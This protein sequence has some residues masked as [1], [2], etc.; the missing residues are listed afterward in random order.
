MIS[1]I[2]YKIAVNIITYWSW[3]WEA[4]NQQD[5]LARTVL[6]ITVPTLVFVWYKWMLSR[7][8]LPPGPYGLPVIGYLPFLSSNL[9]EKFT[10]MAHKYGPIFSLQLGSKLHVVVNSMDLVKVVARE[11]DHTFANRNPP[12]TGLTITYGGMDLVWSNNNTHWRNMRKLLVSKVLS[13]ENLKACQGLRTQEVRK[14]VNEVYARIGTK[15]DINKISFDTGINVV[16]NM[17]WGCSK[18]NEGG[19][20]GHDI[21]DG[22]REVQYKIIE[23]TGT[24]NISDF[25][26]FLSRFDLQGMNQE[27]QRQLEHV[28]RIFDYVIERTM[29]ANSNKINEE[30][31]R[32]DFV[33]ILLELKDEKNDP[34]SFNIIHIKALLINIVVAATDTTTTMVEWVIAEILNNPGVMK[35]V[36]DELTEVIGTTNIVEESHLPKLTYLDAVIKETFRLHPPLPFLIQRCPDEPCVVGGYTIPKGTVVYINVWAIQRDPENWVNPLQF[37][38]E[39]FLKSKWDY[40]G[41]NYKFLPFGT[42]RRICPGLP[43]G[44]KMLVYMLA[45]L[46]H[47]FDWSL[48]K[49]EEFELSDEFGFVTKKRNPLIAIP[50][51]RLSDASLYF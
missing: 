32:K 3:W 4:H 18:S 12:L 48:P 23:L 25:I 19:D 42:G 16:T 27:M 26:P 24:P 6:S 35:K 29:K 9:H 28:D 44:E 46:L 15:I 43:L 30:D 38:P 34:K 5:K 31:G 21:L 45:S 37:K 33:Q 8:H 36:Q 13:N 7:T 2:A 17:L 1:E 47:S 50:S 41:N 51:Q 11:H 20:F 40:N 39:R 14:T 22:F 10:E 49:V